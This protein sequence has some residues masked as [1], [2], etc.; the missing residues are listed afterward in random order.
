MCNPKLSHMSRSMESVDIHGDISHKDDDD[1][2]VYHNEYIYN[3]DKK[4]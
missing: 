1:F 3:L 4:T 2:K